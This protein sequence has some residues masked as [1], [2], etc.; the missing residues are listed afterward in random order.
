MLVKHILG[1][2]PLQG[3]ITISPEDTIK[4]AAGI[5]SEKRIGALLVS[6]G[7]FAVDGILSERDIVRELGTRGPECMADKVADLMTTKV[8]SCGPG[9]TAEYV[10]KTMTQGRFRHMPVV[11]DGKL[12]GV[13]SI[14]DVVKA[15][16]NEISMEKSALEDMIKGF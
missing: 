16:L 10:L 6:G 4:D 14:G 7:G 2:K 15:R 8:E 9:D 1:E 3:V 13:V 12:L 5:L 11:E